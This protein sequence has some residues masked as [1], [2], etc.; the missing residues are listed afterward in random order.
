MPVKNCFLIIL[1]S[2]I[3]YCPL[4]V[5]AQSGA[6]TS[7]ERMT[8]MGPD[9]DRNFDA[10]ESDLAFNSTNN[11]YLM[12]WEGTDQRAGIAP[13]EVEIYGQRVDAEN[14][15]LL[16]QEAFRIS[17]MGT[18][19][20]ANFDARHPVVTYNPTRNEYLVVWS[21]DDNH[22]PLV[23]GEFEIF[24]QRINAADGS[25][26][27][28]RNFRISDMGPNGNR[29]YDATDP[30]VSYNAQ[31]DLYLVVWRGEDGAV[32]IPNG[33]FEI[34]GQLLDGASG[35]P[36]GQNDFVVS[37]MGPDGNMEFAAYSPALA[38]NAADNEFLVV[39]HGDDDSAPLVN[40]E[41]EVFAQRLDAGTGVLAGPAPIRVSDAGANGDI[42]RQATQPDVT[43]NRDTNEY[44]VVWS[45]DDTYGG[46]L[47]GEFEIYG[48]VLT[49]SGVA[50]GQNDFLISNAGGAGNTLFN[51]DEPAIA[52]HGGAHQFVVTW[53]GDDGIDGE[54]EVYSQRLDGPTR[55]PLG[56][57]GQRL[58]HAGP[59]DSL[60]YD[61]RRVAMTEDV[62]SGRVY[63]T[64]EQED[65]TAGQTEGE[66]EAYS[67][68]LGAS[69][70]NVPEGISASWF[71]PAHDGEGWVVEIIN[72][73]QAAVYWFTYDPDVPVQAWMLGV[74]SVIDNRIVMTDV[75]IPTGGVFGPGFDPAAVQFDQWGSFV[76]E[77]ESCN[78][79]GINHNSSVGNFGAASLSP[80]RLTALAGLECPG[81]ASIADEFAGISGSWFDPSHNGEGWVLEYLGDNRM[82]MY[83]FTYD[84]TG[85]QSWLIGVGTVSANVVNID[86][87]L[88]SSGTRFGENFDPQAIVFDH[89]GTVSLTV[90]GCNE[91]TVDY[92]SGDVAYGSGQLNAQRLI[93]LRG[94]SCNLA[95]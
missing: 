73:T 8:H 75:V 39:W 66:F 89:W 5:F 79:A 71:D 60:L 10:Q 30:A 26:V 31:D 74:G 83:W 90:H 19:G 77:F 65:Q 37:S 95:Q 28:T 18:E 84:N 63:I 47:D 3:A 56:I 38:Y 16:G 86:D 68:S 50:T 7:P 51:A 14:G 69:E 57:P 42:S 72:E 25:L 12:V 91:M 6:W 40:D 21:G 15:A 87:V 70:F 85:K 48:Q 61:A 4:T 82:L 81:P 58:S 76:L 49:A 35:Q 22:A 13:G 94:V 23:E 27:G 55:T 11:E 43:W 88:I 45:A 41:L 53:R 24:G 36:V 92:A 29:N 64:W 9:L 2:L 17:F 54:F 59:D 33:Q 62:T 80:I 20:M 67:S 1:L 78:A 44:L 52:Y 46:R 34:Y 32:A 93:A